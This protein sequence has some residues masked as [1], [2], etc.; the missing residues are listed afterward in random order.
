MHDGYS[1][2]AVGGHTR[3]ENSPCTIGKLTLWHGQ[4]NH[5]GPGR[6]RAVASRN[7]QGV[8]FHERQTGRRSRGAPRQFA[9]IGTAEAAGGHAARACLRPQA[10]AK[11]SARDALLPG[12]SPSSHR[13]PIERL[14]YRHPPSDLAR[15]R[16]RVPRTSPPPHTGRGCSKANLLAGMVAGFP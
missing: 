5:A 12:N 8:Q 11:H 15:V 1:V 10:S 2:S 9:T 3:A 13:S 16:V 4:V 6:F 7:A 14:F